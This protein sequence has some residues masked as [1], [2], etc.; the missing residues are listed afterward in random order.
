VWPLCGVLA[1]AAESRWRCGYWGC[2]GNDG[3][4]RAAPKVALSQ[5]CG[6]TTARRAAESTWDHVAAAH[7]TR[8]PQTRSSKSSNGGER[9]GG[10]M[11]R[12]RMAVAADCAFAGVRL[13]WRHQK[14]VRMAARMNVLV[15]QRQWRNA[16]KSSEIAA[17]TAKPRAAAR[18]TRTAQEQRRRRKQQGKWQQR[19]FG[20]RWWCAPGGRCGAR[21]VM[22]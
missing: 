12:R 7:N 20:G 4:G 21:A 10:G 11:E 9:R 18:A 2:S 6:G 14:R 8:A 16:S 19:I 5:T 15:A 1:A 22:R 3:G 17:P 13:W